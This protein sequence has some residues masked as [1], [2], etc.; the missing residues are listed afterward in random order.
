MNF[1]SGTARLLEGANNG[2]AVA[3]EKPRFS[4]PW[5]KIKVHLFNHFQGDRLVPPPYRKVLS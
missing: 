3:T 4:T 5:G 2:L 1:I